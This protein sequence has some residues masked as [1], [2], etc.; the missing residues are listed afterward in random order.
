VQ[1]VKKLILVLATFCLGLSAQAKPH[2]AN[3]ECEGRHIK[4]EKANE[5][6]LKKLERDFQSLSRK[7]SM[8][9]VWGELTSKT[10][11][12]A[13]TPLLSYLAKTESNKTVNEYF[14]T[15]YKEVS[16]GATPEEAMKTWP[17]VLALKKSPHKLN[18]LCEMYKTAGG[19]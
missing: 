19:T 7:Q 2:K 6:D 8:K 3:N 5:I 17:E 18:E 12:R 1:V 4:K 16:G 10:P 9:L 14:L 15:I 11:A 13:T